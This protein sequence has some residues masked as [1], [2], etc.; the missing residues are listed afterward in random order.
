MTGWQSA[1]QRGVDIRAYKSLAFRTGD[2]RISIEHL[3]GV[4]VRLR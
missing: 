3:C 2:H 1:V 4:E